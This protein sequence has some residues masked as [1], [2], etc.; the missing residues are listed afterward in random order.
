MGCWTLPTSFDDDLRAL[1][2]RQDPYPL[3]FTSWRTDL[4]Q[5]ADEVFGIGEGRDV[6][7]RLETTDDD[8]CRRFH[9]ERTHL[10]L[11][12]HGQSKHRS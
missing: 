5:L 10:G 4:A 3:G 9:V 7:L 6:A 8:G 1:L 12:T 11:L 2:W